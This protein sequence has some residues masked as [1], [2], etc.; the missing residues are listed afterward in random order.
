MTSAH[1]FVI[2]S[3][4]MPDNGP[5]SVVDQVT[6]S[7]L[8]MILAGEL[9]PGNEVAIK[10]LSDQ[11]NVSHVPVREALRRLESRGLVVFR[12]G[13]RPQIASADV[14]DFDEIYRLRR[15][16]EVEVASR[17]EGVFTESRLA[18]IEKLMADLR[19]SLQRDTTLPASLSVHSQLHLALLPA[20][21]RWDLQILKQ[22][23]DA[24]ERYLQLYLTHERRQPQ[25]VNRIVAVHQKLVDVAKTGDATALACCVGEHIDGS[26]NSI[27][28]VIQA[29]TTRH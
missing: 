24:T 15:T 11:L 28:P 9:P 20:A 19:A 3:H 5:Q 6:E 23:W 4:L 27:R 21:S 14:K 2:D 17:S 8:V 25:V 16:I 26:T 1:D 10:D 18:I 7:V 13:R 29:L 12:R 22:L